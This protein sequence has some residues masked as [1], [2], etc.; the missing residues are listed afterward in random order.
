MENVIKQIRKAIA[1]AEKVRA[2]KQEQYNKLEDAISGMDID[3]DE[4]EKIACDMW[5]LST[6]ID[7]LDISIRHMTAALHSF[8]WA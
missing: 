1:E 4:A 2:E 6:D 3:T 8:R 5:S 7:L